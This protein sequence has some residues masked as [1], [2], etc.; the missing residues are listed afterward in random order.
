MEF[1]EVPLFDDDIYKLFVRLL[2]NSFFLTMVVI[3][4]IHPSERKRSFTFTAV[5]MNLMVFFLCFTLKKLDLGLG[6]ALGLFAIFAVLR[7]RTDTIRVKQ[8]TYLFIVIGIAVI[9]SLSNKNTSYSELLAVNLLLVLATIAMERFSAR[10]QEKSH[11]VSYDKMELL[12][13]DRRADL[14]AD[15]VAQTGFAITRVDIESID[16]RRQRANLRVF[17]N[18]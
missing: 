17:Y 15:I 14:I 9:N 5:M 3:C 18:K 10:R 13:S 6:M 1:L 11:R 16:L 7:Y 2:I 12:R 8:M 4:A